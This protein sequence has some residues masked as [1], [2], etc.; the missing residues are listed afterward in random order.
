[1]MAIAT[2][3]F[4][5]Q[6]T[7]LTFI[8]QE[9]GSRLLR[10]FL[11]D[12]RNQLAFGTYIST[13]VY[14]LMVLRTIHKDPDDAPVPH[15]AISFGILLAMAGL[16]VLIYSMYHISRFLQSSTIIDYAA[17]D[18]DSTI[19][20]LTGEPGAPAS[21]RADPPCAEGAGLPIPAPAD[22]YIQYVRVRRLLDLCRKADCRLCIHRRVGDFVVAGMPLASLFCAPAR[23]EYVIA[24]ITDTIVLGPQP[25]IEQDLRY[26]VNQLVQIALRAASTDRNDIL[27]ISMCIDRMAGAL[28]LLARRAP[29]PEEWRDDAGAPRVF[30]GSAGF[31]EAVDTFVR[32]LRELRE[33]S[34]TLAV[35]LLT[36]VGIVIRCA[37]READRRLLNREAD[38]IFREAEARIDSAAGREEMARA[39]EAVGRAVESRLEDP[40]LTRG[41]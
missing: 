36:M 12:A 31:A 20:R 23:A 40:L 33:I 10:N 8:G 16:G 37:E 14:A 39:Y 4:S 19:R 30:A 29:A 9:Y 13:F 11:A 22:G 32:P 2:V 24:Q 7:A 1:M 38:L 18:L 6:T 41:S 35:H 21:H 3:M 25:N 15:L 5:S 34:P 26:A 27:T 17:K 28:C